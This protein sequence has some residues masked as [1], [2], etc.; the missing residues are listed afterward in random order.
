MSAKTCLVMIRKQRRIPLSN[1][2]NSEKRAVSGLSQAER[3][4]AS[5]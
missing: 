3:D 5:G 1:E 2:E 4:L